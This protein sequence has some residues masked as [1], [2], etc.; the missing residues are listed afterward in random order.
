MSTSPPSDDLSRLI[1]PWL[2]AEG[3]ELDDLEL[4]GSG[5]GHTLRVLVDAEGGID[6]DHLADV[7]EGIS[8]LLDAGSDLEGPYRL[9]VSSPGL[10]RKLRRPRHFQKSVGREVVVKALVGGERSTVRG[11]LAEADDDGFRVDTGSETVHFSYSEVTSARTVFRWQA[12]PKPG[13]R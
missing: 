1:G 7:S 3:L 8:R 6:L 11:S 5:R 4:V 2:E 12:G 9:E 10:E 13:K